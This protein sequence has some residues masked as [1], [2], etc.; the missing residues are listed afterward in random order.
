VPIRFRV[1]DAAGVS[2][3]TRGVVSSVQLLNTLW[4]P[5]NS[6]VNALGLGIFP[7]ASFQYVAWEK[8]WV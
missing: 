4:L 1:T 6:R 2:I 5:A 7:T 3:G 8:V